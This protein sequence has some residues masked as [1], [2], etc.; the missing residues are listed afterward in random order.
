MDIQTDGHSPLLW[1]LTTGMWVV[2]DFLTLLYGHLSVH[3]MDGEKKRKGRAG[4]VRK[5]REKQGPG[6]DSESG[7]E[8]LKT[9]RGRRMRRVKKSCDSA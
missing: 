5:R 4:G 3:S 7:E 8:G 2:R 9:K 6:G 1:T